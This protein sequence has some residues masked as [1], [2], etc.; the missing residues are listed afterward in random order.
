MDT[1]GFFDGVVESA[2]LLQRLA[3]FEA[4]VVELGVDAVDAV[5]GR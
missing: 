1:R 3:R 5:L 2:R 4:V